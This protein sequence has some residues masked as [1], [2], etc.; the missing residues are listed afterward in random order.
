VS[1]YAL[2]SDN[3]R[4]VDNDVLM[5]EALEQT[6]LRQPMFYRGQRIV[7][8]LELKPLAAVIRAVF[9]RPDWL[10]QWR[11]E[12]DELAAGYVELYA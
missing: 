12:R 5:R 11:K 3:A 1:A 10:A 2:Y 9:H 7:F 6:P 4:W 8:D